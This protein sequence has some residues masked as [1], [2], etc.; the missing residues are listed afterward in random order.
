MTITGSPRTLSDL[1]LD[2]QNHGTLGRL[3]NSGPVAEAE[4]GPDGRMRGR[5][6][7]VPDQ[8]V[9]DP[10]VLYLPHGGRL[11]L[12]IV[13]DDSSTHTVLL[14]SNGDKQ[15]LALPVRSRGKAHLELD[16]PGCYWFSSVIGNDEGSGLTGAIVVGGE[17]AEQ[18]RLDRPEQPRP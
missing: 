13:N 1:G 6:R 16:G 10:A 18:A 11:D 3:L 7:V 12:D 17:V 8:M 15:F 5:L 2:R 9:W 14:P 4:D